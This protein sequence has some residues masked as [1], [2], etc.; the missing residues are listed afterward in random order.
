MECQFYLKLVKATRKQRVQR[1]N[2]GFQN[3]DIKTKSLKHLNHMYWIER[4]MTILLGFLIS[5]GPRFKGSMRKQQK[6]TTNNNQYQKIIKN[7]IES[8][9]KN[10]QMQQKNNKRN[11]FC[12]AMSE[13]EM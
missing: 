4:I 8:M 5:V 10:Y 2:S 3:N 9:P 1:Q 11:I 12:S 6:M 7:S 13:C